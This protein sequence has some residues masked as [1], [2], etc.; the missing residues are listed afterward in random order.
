MLQMKVESLPRCGGSA[1]GMWV[2][3]C[4]ETHTIV[5]FRATLPFIYNMQLRFYLDA[6]PHL[7]ELQAQGEMCPVKC[8]AWARSTHHRPALLLPAPL[9]LSLALPAHLE[10]PLPER[11]P[12]WCGCHLPAQWAGILY[13]RRWWSQMCQCRPMVGSFG[14][15]GVKGFMRVQ[16]KGLVRMEQDVPV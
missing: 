3:F 10:H 1:G 2:W 13:C 12:V 15:V 16:P 9:L 11:R 7:E 5:S 6:S 14:S 8:E 4:G